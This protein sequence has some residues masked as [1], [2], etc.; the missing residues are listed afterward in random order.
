MFLVV[1]VCCAVV[2]A[3][4]AA[5]SNMLFE[6]FMAD[7]S[8]VYRN[9][10]EEQERFQVFQ[11]NLALAALHNSTN[12]A[13][14]GITQFSD[15][16]P[17][18]FEA[19]YLLPSSMRGGGWLL[20]ADNALTRV[21]QPAQAVINNPG[22]NPASCDWRAVNAVTSVKSQGDCASC[23][24]FS[25]TQA[26]ESAWYLANNTLTDLSPQ[27]IV[28]CDNNLPDNGC[29]GGYPY[30]AWKYIT[31]AG[32]LETLAQYPYTSGFGPTQGKRGKCNY[33]ASVTMAKIEGFA[34]AVPKCNDSFCKDQNET[35][36]A[37]VVASSG[38]VSVCADARAWQL[39][40]GGIFNG[41]HIICEA[42]ITQQNHCVGIVGYNT[43]AEGVEYW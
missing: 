21:R 3:Q 11:D 12:S 2:A 27:Q 14:F 35:K 34:W 8:K 40:T 15:L 32:G 22:C 41:S 37:E 17:E 10:E 26:L 33:N 24:A 30:N 16:R 29:N 38:P 1:A 6:K 4:E 19:Q 18:E 13:T 7:F 9:A 20:P 42:D 5:N 28:S 39:Y 36:V 31:T 25:V 23:F 43:T